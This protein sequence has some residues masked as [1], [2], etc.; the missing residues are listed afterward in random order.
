[1]YFPF[2]KKNKDFKFVQIDNY[3]LVNIFVINKIIKDYSFYF[4]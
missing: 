2:L 4:T 3:I 1:M